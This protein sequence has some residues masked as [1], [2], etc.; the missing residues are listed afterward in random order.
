[1]NEAQSRRAAA[2]PPGKDK[3]MFWDEMK[4]FGCQTIIHCN[5]SEEK[6]RFFTACKTNGIIPDLSPY[7]IRN[8]DYFRVC[9]SNGGFELAAYPK[10]RV[11]FFQLEVVEWKGIQSGELQK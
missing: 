11:E 5:S 7:A 10:N 6:E 1:M 9:R 3:P 8:R 2:K 4:K